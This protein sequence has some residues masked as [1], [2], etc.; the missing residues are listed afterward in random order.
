MTDQERQVA[1]TEHR[2]QVRLR[3]MKERRDAEERGEDVAVLGYEL[4][5]MAPDWWDPD[6]P[7]GT[8][9]GKVT[10]HPLQRNGQVIHPITGQPLVERGADGNLVT[11][12]LKGVR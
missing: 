9:E 6:E 2:R 1:W 12:Y 11:R 10:T 5:G 8:R 4:P 7:N 3:R